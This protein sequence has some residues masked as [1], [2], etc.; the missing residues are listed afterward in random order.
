MTVSDLA[1]AE[2]RRSSRSAGND[3]VELVIGGSGATVRDSKNTEFG[4]LSFADIE[5]TAFVGA[6]KGNLLAAG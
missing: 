3:C 1:S 4:H 6:V 5:W 2:W